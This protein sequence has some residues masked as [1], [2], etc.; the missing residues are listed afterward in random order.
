MR[1]GIL[2]GSLRTL[3]GAE[4]VA[5]SLIKALKDKGHEI[6]LYFASTSS[7]KTIETV[8]KDV[9]NKVTVH[10]VFTLKP[11]IFGIYASLI[12]RI[13]LTKVGD[14][15]DVVIETS[16]VLDPL[17]FTNKRYIAYCNGLLQ[18]D[19]TG[20]RRLYWYP[21]S[22]LHT[23]A[24]TKTSYVTIVSNSEY[25]RQLI[26]NILTIDSQVVYPPVDIDFFRFR[27][28][29]KEPEIAVLSR[30]SP[31]KNY[32]LAISVVEHLHNKKFVFAGNV[33]D[34][35]Y[36]KEINEIISRK[37]LAQRVKFEPNMAT[38]DL[39]KI[40]GRAKVYL[41]CRYNEPFGITVI[42]AIAAGCIP[43]V[44]DYS[45]HKETVPFQALRFANVEEASEKVKNAMEGRYDELLPKLQ[46]HI[47]Q[48]DE[49]SFRDKM[50]KLI[51]SF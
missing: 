51:E 19:Y 44:P 9:L 36:Y 48:F 26:K 12:N 16:A 42:E 14:I 41:H 24:R 35:R 27:Q 22:K 50:V 32:E 34:P 25:T 17:W 8:F 29:K 47:S 46:E 13:L 5:I 39:T 2:H 18:V 43:I 11:P 20:L 30:F 37:G 33:G 21:Y 49:N 3:G 28:S 4:R 31:E 7:N 1:I 23:L 10:K 38:D 45:A 15:D 6:D 40:L